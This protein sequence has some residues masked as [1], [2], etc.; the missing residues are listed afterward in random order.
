[1][2]PIFLEERRYDMPIPTEIHQGGNLREILEQKS[3][4]IF[5]ELRSRTFWFIKLRWFVPFSIV[6]VTLLGQL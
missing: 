1:M 6:T 4:I 2:K 3:Q 5:D